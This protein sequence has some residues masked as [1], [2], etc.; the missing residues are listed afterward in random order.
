MQMKVIINNSGF[1]WLLSTRFRGTRCTLP[2]H[3]GGRCVL[4]SRSVRRQLGCKLLTLNLLRKRPLDLEEFPEYR[5]R[6]I[7]RLGG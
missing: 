1:C 2:V 5:Y 6:I 7:D 4:Q 3:L